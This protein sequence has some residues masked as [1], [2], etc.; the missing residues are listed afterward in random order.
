MLTVT[1]GTSSS[2]LSFDALPL[3]MPLRVNPA[4]QRTPLRS[5]LPVTGLFIVITY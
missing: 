3:R 1:L 4:I 2:M 5:L